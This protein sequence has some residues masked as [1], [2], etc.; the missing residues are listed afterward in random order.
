LSAEIEITN[1]MWL[2]NLPDYKTLVEGSMWHVFCQWFDCMHVC[3]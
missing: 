2:D 1:K 3:T